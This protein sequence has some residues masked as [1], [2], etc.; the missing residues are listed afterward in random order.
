MKVIIHKIGYDYDID[1]IEL[2]IAKDHIKMVVRSELK[3]SPS[4]L[5]LF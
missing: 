2:K 4:Q 5:R 3:M 1:I